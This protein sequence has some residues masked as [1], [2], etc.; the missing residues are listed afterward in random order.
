MEKARDPRGRKVSPDPKIHLNL[1]VATSV[2]NKL[3][4][5]EKAVQFCYKAFE[6]ARKPKKRKPPKKTL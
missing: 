6:K 2:V 5:Y 3:G 1:Y 4:G